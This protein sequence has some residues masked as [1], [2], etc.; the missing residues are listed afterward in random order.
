VAKM[1]AMKINNVKLQAQRD[2]SQTSAQP[3]DLN[4]CTQAAIQD[5]NEWA[6]SEAEARQR[7]EQEQSEAKAREAA[8]VHLQQSINEQRAKVAARKL[9]KMK[10]REWDSDK[11]QD[12]QQDAPRESYSSS[13]GYEDSPR[14]VPRASR[15]GYRGGRG[16]GNSSRDNAPVKKALDVAD[17]ADFP[18]LA[19]TA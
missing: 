6:K 10:G 4:V 9:E 7:R 19:T 15:G 3:R 17:K 13:F 18:P 1:E 5:E 11:S 14:P 2:V 12:P 8:R 16:G